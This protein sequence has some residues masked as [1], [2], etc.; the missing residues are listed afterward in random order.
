MYAITQDEVRRTCPLPGDSNAPPGNLWRGIL[1]LS[2]VRW[3]ALGWFE[4][5]EMCIWDL[6]KQ[7]CVYRRFAPAKQNAERRAFGR[8]PYVYEIEDA[9]GIG[10][11]EL[12]DGSIFAWWN[13]KREA[14]CA[15]FDPEDRHGKS[16]RE[17]PTTTINGALELPGGEVLTWGND[18]TVRFWDPG[19]GVM[20]NKWSWPATPGVSHSNGNESAP[21]RRKN[22]LLLW[23]ATALALFD[24]E[25]SSLSLSPSGA[26]SSESI[27]GALLRQDGSLLLWR[28]TALALF[29]TATGTMKREL[30]QA[31]VEIGRGTLGWGAE[32]LHHGRA[33]GV[34]EDAGAR[35]YC[36]TGP[37]LHAWDVSSKNVRHVTFDHGRDIEGG[38]AMA[39]DRVLTWSCTTINVWDIARAYRHLPAS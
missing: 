23:D 16:T 37:V 19:T 34:F 4:N 15:V 2:H 31:D 8:L 11:I 10:G 14:V 30:L 25:W 12:K 24:H 28:G 33:R 1:E 21:L 17:W 7:E 9:G 5:G 27:R 35:V 39:G 32:S 29:D 18:D 26:G 38:F 22:P 6:A 13:W 20:Q 36:W 3:C